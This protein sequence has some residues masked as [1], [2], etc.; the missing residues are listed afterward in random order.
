MIQEKMS[1]YPDTSVIV[2]KEKFVLSAMLLK[3]GECIPAVI[4]AL[5]PDDFY[6]HS[7][8][9]T[10]AAIAKIYLRGDIPNVLTLVEDLRKSGDLE[11][12]GGIEFIYSLAEYANTTA[13]VPQYCKDIKSAADI[14]RLFH[15]AS[16]IGQDAC[17][18]GA[19]AADIIANATAAF[20]AI[21]AETEQ[22][23]FSELNDYLDNCCVQD[24]EDDSKF[25]NVSSGFDNL[26]QNLSLMPGLY[27]FPPWAKLLSSGKFLKIWHIKAAP[28]STAPTKCPK[29]PCS[30]NPSLVPFSTTTPSLT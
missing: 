17:A 7:H 30:E 10:F 5:K 25:A 12:I 19:N 16:Q 15:I 23:Q 29:K 20:S 22:S 28:A 9:K 14:R 6:R 18:V 8:S 26:D 11:N 27:I 13:Y 1:T 3:N 2:E 4:E 21:T 24:F